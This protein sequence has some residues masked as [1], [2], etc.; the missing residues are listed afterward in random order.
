MDTQEC[1]M[2]RRSVRKYRTAPVLDEILHRVMDAA[3]AAPSATNLQP[4]FFAVIRS[5]WAMEELRGIMDT[6]T[7]D[8][9]PG[10]RERFAAHPEVIRETEQ[11]LRR[12]GSAPVC[13]LAFLRQQEYPYMDSARASV[14]AALENLMLAAWNEGLG[15]CWVGAPAQSGYGPVLRDRFAPGMGE[16]VG[17]VV[18]GWPEEIP[19]MPARKAGRCVFI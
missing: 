4:W 15:T 5:Q 8:T 11:F 6:V 12:L 9:L 10:M 13:V 2:T 14:S 19:K 3:L 18:M 17:A 16:L 7:D 1:L